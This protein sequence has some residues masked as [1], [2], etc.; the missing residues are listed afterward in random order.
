MTGCGLVGYGPP[1]VIND[2]GTPAPLDAVIAQSISS[3]S[4][5]P[6]GARIAATNDGIAVVWTDDRAAGFAAYLQ[7]FDDGGASTT[8]E[9]L[10]GVSG[11]YSIPGLAWTGSE[12][13]V[14]WREGEMTSNPLWLSRFDEGGQT[15]GAAQTITASGTDGASPDLAWNG[16][17][18]AGAW[19]AFNVELTD[20]RESSAWLAP[21]DASGVRAGPGGLASWAGD[22]L[23]RPDVTWGP[24]EWAAVAHNDGSGQSPG[25]AAGL[26][27]FDAD[28]NRLGDPVVLNPAD[29]FVQT[30]RIAWNGDEYAVTWVGNSEVWI[31]LFDPQGA[32]LQEPLSLS[33]SARDSD[34]AWVGTHFLVA[35]SQDDGNG[36]ARVMAQWVSADGI[37]VGPASLVGQTG[38]TATT[39]AIASRESR[40]W[41]VWDDEGASPR[42][43]TMATPSN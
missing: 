13:G 24:G 31:N 25:Y 42:T 17:A 33:A 43:L 9:I 32:P 18:F 5:S 29:H 21:I 6:R 4:A 2:D 20:P 10:L 27:R 30:P 39:P 8:D 15:L 14:L 23:C 22:C 37:T 11:S 3:S 12:L 19:P 38:G 41:I 40:F 34:V 1:T 26:V 16:T 7:L 28:G 35:W 36:G